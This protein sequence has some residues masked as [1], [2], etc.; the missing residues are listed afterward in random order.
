MKDR[1]SPKDV[2]L[3]LE[4]TEES[5]L[6]KRWRAVDQRLN[7]ME[8]MDLHRMR[9]TALGLV[10][11]LP[12][13]GLG[14]LS[15]LQG[16]LGFALQGLMLA[17]FVVVVFWMVGRRSRRSIGRLEKDVG[18]LEPGGIEVEPSSAKT[19]TGGESDT[20]RMTLKEDD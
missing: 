6:E 5:G 18:R 8:A 2:P 11:A 9:S 3:N 16:N 13:L 12:L 14:V 7:A 17:V 19:W 4:A 10:V 1:I 20:V 15:L